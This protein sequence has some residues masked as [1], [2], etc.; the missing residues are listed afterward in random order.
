MQRRRPMPWAIIA[1][2]VVIAAM[3]VHRLGRT[4]VP[5][6]TALSVLR[7]MGMRVGSSGIV[8]RSAD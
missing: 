8:G 7:K 3:V 6:N 2:V 4:T 1:S 5:A